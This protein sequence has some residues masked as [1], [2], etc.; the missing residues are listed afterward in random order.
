M[1]DLQFEEQIKRSHNVDLMVLVSLM[2]GVVPQWELE[3]DCEPYLPMNNITLMF[4]KREE[5]VLNVVEK[6]HAG[7]YNRR[8]RAGGRASPGQTNASAT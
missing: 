2:L 6:Y 5:H 8:R 7:K 1:V 4:K 3:F